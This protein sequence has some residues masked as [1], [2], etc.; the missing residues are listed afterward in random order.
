MNKTA[1]AAQLNIDEGRKNKLYRDTVGKL[2]GGVGHNFDAKGLSEAVID[3]M[4]SEDIDDACSDLDRY[5]P[6]WRN[7]SDAR[8]QV[9]CNMTFNMGIQGVLGFT[10]TLAKMRSGDYQGAADGM[11]NS[12]W[13]TQ[14]GA[15]AQ[16]LIAMMRAG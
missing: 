9:L 12:K 16:R 1:L 7:L 14:V 10:N 5:L 11:A 2:T 15:R 3:L 4:L 6:W 13:A 8:Q